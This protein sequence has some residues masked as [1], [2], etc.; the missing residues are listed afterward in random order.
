VLQDATVHRS[1]AVRNAGSTPLEISGVTPSRFCSATIEPALIAPGSKGD[2]EVTCRADLAGPLRERLQIESNDPQARTATFE[3]VAQVTPLLAFDV[4]SVNLSMPFGQQ[5]LQEVRLTGALVSQARP[6]L[7]CSPVADTEIEPL[8]S[9]TGKTQ[10]YRIR[11][12]GRKVGMHAG[13]LIVETGLARPEKIALPYA[14]RISGT[15]KVSPTN[16]YLNLKLPGPKVVSVE[17]KSSQPGF[18][19]VGARV[20]EGPFAA[21]FEQTGQ[22]TFVVKVSVLEERVDEEAHGITGKLVI[23]SNDRTE[24]EKELPLF[25]F[26][27]LRR[28]QGT[29]P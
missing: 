9:P 28:T 2:L 8:T 1:V 13:S 19:V 5:R 12:R 27:K 18:R 22:S 17:V 10:G 16:P 20:T 15:L 23:S 24:P 4:P 26:G 21:S 25:G 7:S 14:C 29:A 3:L 6:R 11:C